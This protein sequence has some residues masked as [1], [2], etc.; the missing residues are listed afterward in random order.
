ML[1]DWLQAKGH[2]G[3]NEAGRIARQA[4]IVWPD[5]TIWLAS[6]PRSGNTYLR[7]LLWSC[8]RLQSGSVY[9]NDLLK[10]RGVASQVGHN[11]GASRGLFSPEFLRL[12]LVKTH[13]WPTDDRKAIYILRDGTDACL[14]LGKY[15]P[16]TGYDVSLDDIIAGRHHFGSW[17]GHVLA[18]DPQHRPNT[19]FLRFEELTGD[20][21]GTLDRLSEFLGLLPVNMAPPQLLED[22]GG[23]TWLSPSLTP[24]RGLTAR[25]AEAF[26][27]LHGETMARFGY[28]AARS[29]RA[30]MPIEPIADKAAVVWLC[31]GKEHLRQ[32]VDSARSTLSL[33][34]DRILITDAATAALDRPEDVFTKI[35]SAELPYGSHLNKSRLIDLIPAGYDTIL[36]LDTDTKVLGDI[37]LG[38]EQARKYGIALAP[39]PHYNLG[40]FF[41]FDAIM[42]D[43]GMPAAGQM[44][45]NAGVIFC[46]L[47]GRGRQVLERFR[48]LCAAAPP[49]WIHD[50]PYLT[51]AFE[52]LGILPYV[53]SPLYNYR[54]FGELAVGDIR[55]WHSIH[56]PPADLTSG[57]PAWPPRRY[58]D[59]VRVP[60]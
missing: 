14:S 51:L 39:A 47:P 54:G 3:R 50:Q 58:R 17:S 8:F 18:W 1:R 25:Q 44:L 56:P 37:S 49:G 30:A 45:Y 10:N 57:E 24:K 35:V 55:I 6:Y 36:Y 11:E 15:L 33:G 5:S 34:I 46:H 59:G 4:D 53:L 7:A 22:R 13:E 52:Q 19:L 42:G 28:A 31:W 26:D 16:A 60:A 38:F 23:P 2:S 12:P 40:G 43:L 9:P 32:A 27:A 20:F 29:K 41:G 21:A 48:D